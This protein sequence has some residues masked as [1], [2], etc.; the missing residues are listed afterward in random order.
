MWFTIAVGA[1]MCVVL[2][3]TVR[4]AVIYLRKRGPFPLRRLTLRLSMAG[5][6]LFLLGSI[7]VGV[8]SFGLEVPSGHE[9]L[10]MAFWTCIMLLTGAILCLVVADLRLLAEENHVAMQHWQEVA[11]MLDKYRDGLSPKE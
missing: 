11:E 8:R 7:L 10:W 4:E 5:M 6:L 2:G 3:M 1:A 9:T